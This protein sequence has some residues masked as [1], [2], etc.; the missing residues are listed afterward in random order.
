[1]TERE[2][3]QKIHNEIVKALNE[4]GSTIIGKSKQMILDREIYARGDFYR[5]SEYV[6]KGN[7]RAGYSV[8][9]GSN[10]K[11]EP[12]VLGG[13][14]PSWTPLEPLKAWVERKGLNWTD[15]KTGTALTTEQMARLIR[16]KIKREGIPARNVFAEILN[17][18]VGY[19]RER[20][21]RI[22]I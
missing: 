3:W 10:V 19:V 12:Y 2:F 14:E 13:K 6:Q 7:L 20:L 15:K 22:A 9:F 8:Q 16:G 4:I 1:M 21:A 17:D 5:N 11:H 18:N